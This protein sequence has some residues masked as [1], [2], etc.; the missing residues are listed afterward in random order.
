MEILIPIA[1]ILLSATIVCSSLYFSYQTSKSK[2]NALVEVSKNIDDPSQLEELIKSL[3]EQKDPSDPRRNGV[4]TFFTGMGIYIFGVVVTQGGLKGVGLLVAAIGAG[5]VI[6]GY[7]F[8]R[9]RETS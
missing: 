1:G 3:E 8:P 7:L 4:V 6:A 2:H 5:I 9:G